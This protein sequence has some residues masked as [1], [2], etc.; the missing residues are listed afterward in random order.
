MTT[1][2]LDDASFHNPLRQTEDAEHDELRKSAFQRLL[3][4]KHY[5]ELHKSGIDIVIA[6]SKRHEGVGR[7]EHIIKKIKFLLASALKTWNFH[8]S[9]DFAHKVALINHYLNERPLFYTDQDICTPLTLEQSLLARSNAKPKFVTFAEYLIPS[10]KEI[11]KQIKK[12]A[13]FNKKILLEVAANSAFYLLNKRTPNQRFKEQD[14]VYVPNRLLLKNPH[15][16]SDALG[17]ISVILPSQ[18]DYSILLLD[19]TKI[20]RHHLD[21]VSALATKTNSDLTLI[22]PFQLID[23]RDRTPP[24]HL[25]PK[26]KVF[27]DKFKEQHPPNQ[28]EANHQGATEPEA[29]G[30]GEVKTQ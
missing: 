8:D 28:S 14:L 23:W 17:R 18:R 30:N 29:N 21:I 26:L 13:D 3:D 22:D 24:D 6:S 10:N 7:A 27:M 25:Y 16:L 9:F 15:S 11:Y 20:T 19:G 5:S 1:I 2:I 4:N 12:L